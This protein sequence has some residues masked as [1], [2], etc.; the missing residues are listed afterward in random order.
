MTVSLN[1]LEYGS[2][3]KVAHETFH[4]SFNTIIITFMILGHIEI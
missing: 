4:V 3:D 1:E 2:V